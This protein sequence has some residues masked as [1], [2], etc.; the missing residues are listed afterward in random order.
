[1]SGPADLEGWLRLERENLARSPLYLGEPLE[2]ALYA[3]AD[4]LTHHRLYV[5][6]RDE[7]NG[8]IAVLQWLGTRWGVR[9]TPRQCLHCEAA[10]PRTHDVLCETCA[11]THDFIPF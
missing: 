11:R 6:R 8:W 10:E 7:Q 9:P 1:M 2:N 3:H 4:R 5:D